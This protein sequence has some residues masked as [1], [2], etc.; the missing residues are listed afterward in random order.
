MSSYIKHSIDAAF[1]GTKINTKSFKIFLTNEEGDAKFQSYG[2]Q[3]ELNMNKNTIKDLNIKFSDR[4]ETIRMANLINMIRSNYHPS[5]SNE[6]RFVMSPSGEIEQKNA[7]SKRFSDLNILTDYTNFPTLKGKAN[8]ENKRK[9]IDYLNKTLA[10]V[11]TKKL[12]KKDFAA[13][14]VPEARFRSNVNYEE[15]YPDYLNKLTADKINR[16]ITQLKKEGYI[17]DKLVFL[18]GG[19]FLLDPD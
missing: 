2:H 17:I 19:T 10:N 1:Y 8:N 6:A 4:S 3:T 15:K 18:G 16:A 7:S 14:L 11:E 13:L 9:L 5:S 12:N